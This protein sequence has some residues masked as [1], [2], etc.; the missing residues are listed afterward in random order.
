MVQ[1]AKEL[2]HAHVIYLSPTRSIHDLR[3]VRLFERSGALVTVIDSKNTDFDMQSILDFASANEYP[4]SNRAKVLITGPLV[5][6]QSQLKSFDI[7]V[8]GISWAF[9][10][11]RDSIRNPNELLKLKQSL[12]FYHQIVVDNHA[13]LRI[14]VALGY[15]EN[16]ILN[17]PW[18]VEE[19]RDSSTCQKSSLNLRMGGEKI[20]L[21][22]RSLLP[23]YNQDLV[24]RAFKLVLAS[25]P[26]SK[27]VLIDGDYNNRKLLEGIAE[28]LGIAEQII[29]LPF[30]Q[31]S[32]T[33]DWI[34]DSDV[35]VSAASTDGSSVTILQAM[36]LGI[37]VV[38]SATLGS[39]SWIFDGITG[40]TFGAGNERGCAE[41]IIR[42][43]DS[44]NDQVISNAQELIAA[45]A[46]WPQVATPLL[47]SIKLLTT[48]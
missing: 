8:I 4:I 11:M 21:S 12:N 6:D 18:G 48:N 9:D 5:L 14:L 35:I 10:I 7:P 23:H 24:L 15:P 17:F 32:Q 43:L 1:S 19:A 13:S 40:F 45:K 22:P 41:A 30:S 37:P 46:H 3:F 31:E 26:Y 36:K 39:A 16:K 33:E 2:N 47:E 34:A 25:H 27:L 42:A 20:I 28:T 29:W 44:D 38:T